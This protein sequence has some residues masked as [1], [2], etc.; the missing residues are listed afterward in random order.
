M[1]ATILCALM[2]GCVAPDCGYFIRQFGIASFAHTAAG[3]LLVSAPTGMVLYLA[4]AGLF[5]RI[6]AVLPEPHSGF[7]KSWNL[8]T[9][10]R[11]AVTPAVLA[12][13][14]VGALSHNLVDSFTHE[15]G[16]AVSMFPVLRATAFSAG[17][18]TI[19][20]FRVLQN[21]GSVLGMLMIAST[22]LSGLRNHCLA[23]RTRIWQDAG[24]WLV[25]TSLAG[26]TVLIAFLANARILD[27]GL[28]PYSARAFAF[29]FVISWI[30]LFG[31]AFLCLALWH[32]RKLP[33]RDTDHDHPPGS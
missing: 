13:I 15:R 19:P 18:T 1:S 3:A 9:R 6:A 12:A 29:A 4:A 27:G 30:P 10:T 17:G 28:D 21:A 24:K 2:A 31:S 5:R 22:Y 7:W 16:M 8:H 23:T 25:L 26:L 14:A 33:A 20:V 32:G 11:P